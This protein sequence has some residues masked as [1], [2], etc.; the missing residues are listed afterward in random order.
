MKTERERVGSNKGDKKNISRKTMITRYEEEEI[1]VNG[2][3]KKSLQIGAFLAQLSVFLHF[4]SQS[5]IHS[6][7]ASRSHSTV[8]EPTLLAR[9]AYECEDF[10]VVDLSDLNL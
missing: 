1:R 4:L 7:C 5:M 6:R 2:E 10:K 9:I 8:T 3:G